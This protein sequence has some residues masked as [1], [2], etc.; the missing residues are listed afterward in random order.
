MALLKVI[1]WA[2]IIII[3][4]RFPPGKNKG[5]FR[6]RPIS[7]FVYVLPFVNTH[8]WLLTSGSASEFLLFLHEIN[9]CCS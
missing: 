2:L 1:C 4:I 9:I 7:A 6:S 8:R 5:E 3:R